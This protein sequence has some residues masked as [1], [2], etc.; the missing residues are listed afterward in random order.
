[1]SL[2]PRDS[3][4]NFD[5]MFENF[6]TPSRSVMESGE[7]F[8]TPRI[9]IRETKKNYEV[10]AE[11]PGVKKEDL[12]VTLEN[13]MLT[14]EAETRFEERKEEEGKLMRQERRYGKFVRSF[15]LESDI[16]EKDIDATFKD[17]VLT[18]K[19][20]RRE[21]KEPEVKRIEIH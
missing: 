15:G 20:P 13:G 9:D 6:F 4:F 8:F 5:N 2:I 19:I 10:S 14:V 1:M 12:K 7:G 21:A 16:K 18:L 17:G 3:L 11:L